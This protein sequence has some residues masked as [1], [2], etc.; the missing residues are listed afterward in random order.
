MVGR[1]A[2]ITHIVDAV[3]G[4]LG[5]DNVAALQR[6][7]CGLRS[8]TQPSSDHPAGDLHLAAVINGLQQLLFLCEMV[9]AVL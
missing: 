1:L 5:A 6:P 9:Y 2:A 7:E 8:A 3:L 4:F